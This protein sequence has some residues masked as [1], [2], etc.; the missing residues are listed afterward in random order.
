MEKGFVVATLFNLSMN[1]IYTFAAL[2]IGVLALGT[3]DKFLLKKI[4][5]QDELKKN[6][7][8]VAIFAST[9]LLFVAI[10]ISFGLR[11]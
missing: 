6:N 10:I 4:D 7:I 11:G 5:I 1:L 9:M 3:V 2:I 8:A